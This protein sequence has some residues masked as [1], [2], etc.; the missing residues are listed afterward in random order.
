MG[1]GLLFSGYPVGLLLSKCYD[2]LQR[3]KHMT[4]K[5]KR[6]SWRKWKWIVGVRTIEWKTRE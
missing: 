4:K 2:F 1:G 3:R 5:W 6:I